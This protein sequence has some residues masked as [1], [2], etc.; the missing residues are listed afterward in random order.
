VS[1]V[2][3]PFA[4]V[5]AAG[6]RHFNTRVEEAKRRAPGFDAAGFAAF[7]QQQVDGVV[8]A[9]HAVAPTRMTAVAL[10]AYDIAISLCLHGLAGPATRVPLLNQ[11][12]SRLFPLLAARIAEQPQDV[13][14]ALS[15]AIVHLVNVD[16][17]RGDEWLDLMVQLAPGAGTVA[18]LLDLGKVLAWRA[19]L[20]HFRSGALQA[21]DNLPPALQLAALGAPIDGSWNALRAAL[22][23]DP[24]AAPQPR[25]TEGWQLGAF[26]GF[27]GRFPQPPE[28]RLSPAGFLVR[29]GTRHF[30]VIADAFGA[31]LLPA[32]GEEFAAGAVPPPPV[33][34]QRRGTTLVFADRELVLDLPTEGLQLAADSHTLAVASPYSHT[35]RLVPL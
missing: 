7:L 23:A 30:L 12:W 32:S 27:G 28:L 21:A 6:R 15:N 5:L 11:A 33:A 31:V 25:R 29:S 8:V 35:L 13:L 1:A 26:T 17:A 22:A 14:G 3:A 18:Q 10:A 4:Q 34:P 20:A 19:G 9:V 16:G 24:W 2:S